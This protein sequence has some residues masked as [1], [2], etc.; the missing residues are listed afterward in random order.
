[1]AFLAHITLV[2]VASL[3]A[4]FVLGGLAGAILVLGRSRRDAR[5]RG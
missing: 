4:A 1:M 2:D 3:L 5:P